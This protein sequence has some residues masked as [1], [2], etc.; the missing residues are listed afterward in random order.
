[1]NLLKMYTVEVIFQ[2]VHTQHM[3]QFTR[4]D[5]EIIVIIAMLNEY[6]KF[7]SHI[8]AAHTSV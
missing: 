3:L 8:Y 5:S 7:R 4:N 1:M 6:M 2:N